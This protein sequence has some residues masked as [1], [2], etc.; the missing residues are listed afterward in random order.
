MK[1]F[2]CYI[3]ITL[4]STHLTVAQNA[5]DSLAID[6]T[7]RALKP[8]S[9]NFS[10]KYVGDT[11]VVDQVYDQKQIRKSIRKYPDYK[12]WMFMFE[13]GGGMRIAQEPINLPEALI[14]YR[15]GLKAGFCLGGS[16]SYFM[17]PILAFGFNY[18]VFDMRNHTDFMTWEGAEGTAFAGSRK[19]DIY[20]HFFGPT[21]TI[22]TIPRRNKLYAWY[23]FMIG[24]SIFRDEVTINSSE[25]DFIGNSFGFASSVGVDFL[26]SNKCSAGL[27]LQMSAGAVKNVRLFDYDG[28]SQE[29][30]NI[31][32]L[33]RV[34]LALTFKTFR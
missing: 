15:K 21:L 22:R 17:N 3:V 8:I 9:P 33:S 34:S 1:Y 10:L 14:K 7:K 24:H 30:N 25:Y 29:I 27:V 23:T 6:S 13:S 28:G 31:D 20:I 12:R 19:D 11:V 16:A 18:S 26:L 4:A 32:N 2:I 5:A